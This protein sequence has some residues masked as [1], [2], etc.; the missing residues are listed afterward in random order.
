MPLL[1]FHGFAAVALASAT[2]CGGGANKA[3]A[4]APPPLVQGAPE[5]PPVLEPVA[6]PP[7]LFAVT[8]IRN[9]ARLADVG[10]RWTSLPV[11]W[12][13]MVEKEL[14]GIG[15]VVAFDAPVDVAA[16]LDRSS[17]EPRVFWA[18]AIGVSSPE[19]AATYFRDK[20]ES[21]VRRGI[22]VYAVRGPVDCVVTPARGAA[23][24]RLVCSDGMDSV[25]ALSPYMARGL[26][27]ETFGTSDVHA[28]VTA[29]PFRK[30]Y[31]SELALIKTMG[32]PF[33]LRELELG[34]PKFD[35]ALRSVMYDFADELIA[36]AKDVQRIDLDASLSPREDAI[37]VHAMLTMNGQ[38]SWTAQAAVRAAAAGGP[39]PDFFW[40]L[41][42]DATAASYSVYA[43]PEHTRGIAASL[44]Q[45]LEGWLDYNEL[46]E[47]RRR[48]LVD[49]FVEVLTTNAR[50]A[51]TSLPASSEGSSSTDTTKPLVGEHLF[52][53]DHGGD[54]LQ[55]FAS[56]LVKSMNSRP[57][58]E[59]LVKSKLL[60][61]EQVP[62]SRERAPKGKKEGPAGSKTF[63]FEFPANAF[64]PESAA[65]T[66]PSPAARTKKNQA[67]GGKPGKKPDAK[68][69]V[70]LVAV[71]DGPY[72]WFG[73]GTD[74]AALLERLLEAKAG[75]GST[76]VLRDG[77]GPLHTDRAVSAGFSSLAALA[78]ALDTGR[79]SNGGPDLT[80]NL[81]RLP[82]RGEVPILWN[83]LFDAIGPKITASS[84]IP[85]AVVEDL[86][87]LAVSLRPRNGF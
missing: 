51:Y 43:D 60:K 29:D 14:P 7:E 45:L 71:P 52:V 2:A 65:V 86:I 8:R 18:F 12:R 77:L 76:L 37:D 72:T 78:A 70:V 59:R 40:R 38:Q 17:I 26:P 30:R 53:L 1:R 24:A 50:S 74:E 62:T 82:H 20:G 63:E 67:A 10:V 27:T 75:N 87:A 55:R 9:V 22:G 41:P 33:L 84:S 56:E 13:N 3:P 23:P 85:Q 64:A 39:A 35:R 54:R 34:H 36:L 81:A 80:R 16:M 19:A 25:D 44:G 11:D 15:R 66:P 21:V 32:V 5:A 58:R 61:A 68:T 31:G 42:K 28:H 49:A 69:R 79:F 73:F 47:N 83:V 6:A 4:Q 46:P 57:F 48:P